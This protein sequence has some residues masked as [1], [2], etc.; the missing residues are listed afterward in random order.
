M[1]WEVLDKW[2]PKGKSEIPLLLMLFYLFCESEA[3]L[4]PSFWTQGSPRRA[5]P[6]RRC[7]QIGSLV[8]AAQ[9]LKD[10]VGVLRS[11]QQEQKSRVE[12][13]GKSSFDFDFQY[14]YELWKRGLSIL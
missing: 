9:L 13:K 8:G 12:Q 1:T 2:E 14:E 5:D 11:A 3:R 7:Y 4:Y 6:G 10:N